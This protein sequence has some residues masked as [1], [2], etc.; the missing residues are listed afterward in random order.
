MSV[1][2]LAGFGVK[3]I[4]S[5]STLTPGIG[6]AVQSVPALAGA[7]FLPFHNMA[8]IHETSSAYCTTC[9]SEIVETINDSCFNDGECGPCEYQRYRSQP[10]LLD[11]CELALEEIKQWNE[12]M[13]GSEDPRTHEAITAL[14][15]AIE[16]AHGA[17]A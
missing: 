8:N 12:V 5:G 4:P 6:R 13:G 3:V 10:K 17:V 2:G 1:H 15:A 9:G 7:D 16:I 11:A 14:R